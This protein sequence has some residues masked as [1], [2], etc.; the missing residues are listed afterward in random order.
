MKNTDYRRGR[1]CGDRVIRRKHP[2]GCAPDGSDP[3]PVHVFAAPLQT[4][5]HPNSA[6][7]AIHRPD[8]T[9]NSKQTNKQTKQKTKNDGTNRKL[10]VKIQFCLQLQFYRQ[11]FAT[12]RQGKVTLRAL[13]SVKNI[14]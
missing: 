7:I 8:S 11:I 12:E 5:L 13:S 1:D 6:N 2:D 3:D 14:N 9:F 10:F 4:P